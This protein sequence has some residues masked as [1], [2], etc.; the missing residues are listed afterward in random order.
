[1][2]SQRQYF[3]G[4]WADLPGGGGDRASYYANVPDI[5]PPP[6]V[7]PHTSFGRSYCNGKCCGV[8]T[9]IVI[10]TDEK[11]IR[12]DWAAADD[13]A[14]VLELDRHRQPMAAKYEERFHEGWARYREHVCK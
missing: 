13:G 10:G 5:K 3:P 6:P 7:L 2:T 12:L 1:M 11:A 14:Y 4:E 8:A 9:C